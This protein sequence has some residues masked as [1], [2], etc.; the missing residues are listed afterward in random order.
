MECIQTKGLVLRQTDYGEADR[1]LTIFTEE[2]GIIPVIAKGVRK[3]KSHQRAASSLFCYGEYSLHAGKNMYSMR[4]CKLI[5]SFYGISSGIE[6]LALASYLCEITA[7]FVPEQEIEN[8]VLSLILNTLYILSEKE[9]SLFLIKA[10]FELKLLSMVGY[11]IDTSRCVVC[12][13]EQTVCFSPDKGGMLCPDC[14]LSRPPQPKS[15]AAAIKYILS[16]DIKNIFSFSIDE[17]GLL[18][19]SKLAEQFILK[20]SERNFQTLAYFCD[21]CK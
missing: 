7:Y 21:V 9:R 19:L 17:A 14:A 16:G 2:K 10:V 4:G 1:I 8:E 15:A 12:G 3:Y 11:E 5:E 20:I 13:K 18:S 6:K